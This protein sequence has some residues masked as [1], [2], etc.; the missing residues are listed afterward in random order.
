MKTTK[1]EDLPA[2]LVSPL[3]T[4]NDI[5]L[6]Y[7]GAL[8]FIIQDTRRDP[9]YFDNHLLSY[10]AQDFLQSAISIVTLSMEGL[11]SVAKR[12]LRFIIETS[13][14][15]CFV[16]QK[17]YA[18]TIQAKLERFD[19]ELSSQRISIKQNLE[20]SMLPDDLKE[21]F[22]EEVGRVYGLTSNYVHL[23]PLQ[24][25]ERIAAV[26]AGR[27]AGKES[28]ADVEALNALL[29]RGLAISLTLL[30]HSVPHYIAGDWMVEDDGSTVAWYFAG[31]RFLAGID[32]YFDYKV[33]RQQSLA[34]IQNTR[35]RAV[36]F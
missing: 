33:E 10:L 13:I 29:S 24:I 21:P 27:T 25:Q 1:I 28:G 5:I 23:T 26:N 11:I 8:N 2:D 31:S 20:F 19:K 34:Q 9:A 7:L 3:K 12:E 32:S 36:S 15:L 18:S 6:S 22:G 14:K 16:Q 30:F 17:D 35:R 4:T